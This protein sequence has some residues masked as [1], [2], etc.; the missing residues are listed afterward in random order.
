MKI[1]TLKKSAQSSTKYRGH[2]MKWGDVFGNATTQAFGLN[3]KCRDCGSYCFII[4]NPAP[5]QTGVSGT[6]VALNCKDR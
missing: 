3:G 5:N 1:S 4:T 2:R 6:A